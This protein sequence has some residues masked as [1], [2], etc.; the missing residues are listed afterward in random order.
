MA[1]CNKQHN[2]WVFMR[3]NRWETVLCIF[4]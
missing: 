1:V 4:C 3:R 2:W